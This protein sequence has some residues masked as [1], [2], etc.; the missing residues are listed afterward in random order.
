MNN[1]KI[2]AI[3]FLLCTI[4]GGVTIFERN[5]VARTHTEI[6]QLRDSVAL[7]AQ[8]SDESE[9]RAS[10]SETIA[11]NER[12]RLEKL[13]QSIAHEKERLDRHDR[14]HVDSRSTARNTASTPHED[15]QSMAK[16]LQMSD[17]QFQ[18]IQ[19]QLAANRVRLELPYLMEKMKLT[20]AQADGLERAAIEKQRVL[21]DIAK[22]AQVEGLTN[23]TESAG[24]DDIAK[25]SLVTLVGTDTYEA[26]SEYTAGQHARSMVNSLTGSLYATK[27][28]L[29]REQSEALVRIVRSNSSTSSTL[30]SPADSQSSEDKIL[31]QSRATLSQAQFAAFEAIVRGGQL[32]HKMNQRVA[33]LT[34]GA[35]RK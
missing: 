22:A 7:L 35:L 12:R 34:E 24:L 10:D 11:V 19:R 27:E 31:E 32:A 29:T 9:K 16:F 21:N 13:E 4:A 17:P 5:R 6:K 18:D 15:A 14:N 30:P 28:P 20:P 23:P 33:T 2:A 8:K 26:F 25:E 1:R 3:L